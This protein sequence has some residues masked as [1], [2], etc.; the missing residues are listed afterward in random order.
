MIL[1]RKRGLKNVIE[2]SDDEKTSLEE[3]NVSWKTRFHLTI[4]SSILVIAAYHII[5]I[6]ST[7]VDVAT[8]SSLKDSPILVSSFVKVAPVLIVAGLVGKLISNKA[9]SRPENTKK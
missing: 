1:R 6:T 8:S 4:Y 7:F 2:N 9:Y 3:R 5:S